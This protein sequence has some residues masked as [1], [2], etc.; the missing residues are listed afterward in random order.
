MF[1]FDFLD[2]T[3]GSSGRATNG[4]IKVYAVNYNI[5]QINSG[6]GSLLYYTT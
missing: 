2:T 6:Q 4:M 3:I 5:L 1:I